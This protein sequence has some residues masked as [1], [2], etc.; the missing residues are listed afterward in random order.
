MS[1]Q[2]KK[3]SQFEG[4]PAVSTASAAA[5][6]FAPSENVTP[7]ALTSEPSAGVHVPVSSAGL[8]W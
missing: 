5:T 4:I 6:A 3:A 8:K 2:T 1:S 7:I